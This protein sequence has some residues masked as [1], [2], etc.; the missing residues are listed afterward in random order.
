MVFLS[1]DEN[2]LEVVVERSHNFLNAL[3]PLDYTLYFR[4]YFMIFKLHFNLKTESI[5]RSFTG[6]E[7]KPLHTSITQESHDQ[8]LYY[9]IRS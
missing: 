2:I 7:V 1:G 5:P 4:V 9:R 3:K 8:S 6:H